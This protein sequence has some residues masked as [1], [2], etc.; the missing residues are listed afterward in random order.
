M[1][2]T[3]PSFDRGFRQ[4]VGI[5]TRKYQ[6]KSIVWRHNQDLITSMY[7]KAQILIKKESVKVHFLPNYKQKQHTTSVFYLLKKMCGYILNELA[8]HH[9]TYHTMTKQRYRSAK[10]AL[11][12]I[13]PNERH[14]KTLRMLGLQTFRDRRKMFRLSRD[15]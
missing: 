15:M 13:N 9:H 2:N 3:N 6:I 10:M 11:Q 5:K 12:L 8:R 14:N 7:L 1:I 4:C